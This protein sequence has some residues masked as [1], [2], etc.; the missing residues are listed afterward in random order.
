[1]TKQSLALTSLIA[2]IPGL[3]LTVLMVIAFISH[4]G[5]TTVTLKLLAFVL[6]LAGGAMAA[7]P[8]GIWVRGG[9]DAKSDKK[10]GE[11][12]APVAAEPISSDTIM[13]G[14]MDEVPAFSGSDFGTVEVAADLRS[15]EEFIE[16]V[17]QPA[18]EADADDELDLGDEFDLDI[19]EDDAP[20][21]KK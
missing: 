8:A 10:K 18:V 12:K 20:P 4:A 14:T 21:R 6:L 9:P 15:S 19:D 17:A 3:F 16:T 5:G 7:L 2:A 1:M 11:T 13:L